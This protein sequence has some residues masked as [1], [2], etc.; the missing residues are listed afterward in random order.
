MHS[1]LEKM[2]IKEGHMDDEKNKL[3]HSFMKEKS[4]TFEEV[5][6]SNNF[7]DEKIILRI[8]KEK[9]SIQYIDLD[10][11][12]I[13]QKAIDGIS[14]EQA[15]KYSVLPF[16]LVGDKIFAAFHNPINSDNVE[17]ISFLTKKQVI[18]F[19][20]L[21]SQIDYYINLLY[22]KNECENVLKELTGS[23]LSSKSFENNIQDVTIEEAPAVRLVD[24]I[25]SQAIN[26]K[27]S[28]IHIE[29]FS[30]N[31]LIRI[32]ING[33]LHE[34]TSIPKQ[35]H[36]T[37]CTRIK[38]MAK[39]N[40]AINRIPQDGKISYIY[41]SYK[42]DLRVSSVPTIHGEKL[43][44]R[45][46][47]NTIEYHL[48]NPQLI[49][50]LKMNSQGTIIITGPTGS[51]KSSTLYSMINYLNSK[52]RNIVTIEDPVEYSMYGINQ[53]EVNNKAGLTFSLGL[54][55]ILRQ[56]P[57][58]IMVGEVRD[59]ETAKI[60][61]RA[62]IT[63]HLVLTTMHTNDSI[64]SVLRLM[65]MGVPQ[66]L[67]ADALTAVVA[68]RLVRIICPHCKAEYKPSNEEIEK[69]NLT[70]H[71]LFHG[72][73]C[74]KCNQTGYLGRRALFEIM[75]LNKKHREFIVNGEGMNKLRQYSLQQGMI[76]LKEGGYNLVRQGITTYKEVMNRVYIS[77]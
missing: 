55:S 17:E 21:K 71:V 30:E 56:D 7:I 4:D 67:V 37:L 40:I 46:L 73:G 12:D 19:K 11:V 68:Q 22:G 36:Q 52:E 70:Q 77:E 26:E 69:L 53:M 75:Y 33:I 48:D 76:S 64:S 39:I 74:C 20:G 42:Y 50:I 15:I 9:F 18:P 6:F 14:K 57:D 49:E 1:K 66:Y 27:A 43:V 29:P 58:V 28:D 34:L 23:I 47:Y 31:V 5:V 32:R 16:K 13:Q 51:G 35:V 65:D 63:G 10:E 60:A 3:V 45:I 62:A 59:D 72:K 44:L 8:L 25:L 61:V 24:Y 41:S 54:K 38:V 2:L